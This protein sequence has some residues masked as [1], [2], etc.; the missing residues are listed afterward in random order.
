MKWLRELCDA[1]GILLIAD[2]IQSARSQKPI[3]AVANSLAASAAYWIGC[4][5]NEFYVRPASW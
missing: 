3:V 1:H 2:E 5:A 4:S